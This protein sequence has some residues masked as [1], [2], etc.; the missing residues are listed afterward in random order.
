MVTMMAAFS[1][2]SAITWKSS[3]AATSAKRDIA[4]FIDDD[5]LHAGPAG[6][7]AAQTLFA[8][9]FDEL[10]DQRRGS[11]KAHSPPLTTGGDSQAGGKMTLAGAGVTDQQDWLGAFEIAAFGQGADAGGRDVRRLSEVELF[12]RLDPGQVR[13]LHPQ[14]DRAAFAVF[15]LRLKQS[16]EIV[17]MGVV[18]LTGFF[19]ERCE[20]RT[21]GSQSQ[22]LAVLGDA[23]GLEA[24]AC[25]A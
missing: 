23:C 24:H 13:F 14:L 9:R 12:E 7:H 20:L 5:Q 3:S 4:E 8:L 11:R 15:H 17:Q 6:Q 1:A 22:S 16:L 25:T 18:A 10:V 21:D 19:G 2:L